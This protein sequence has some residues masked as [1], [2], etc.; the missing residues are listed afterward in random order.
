MPNFADSGITLGAA[1]F[2]HQQ[3][4]RTQ[5]GLVGRLLFP[6]IPY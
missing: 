6:P 3:E 1:V 2:A 5:W 4:H